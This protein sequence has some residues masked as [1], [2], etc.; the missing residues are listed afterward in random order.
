MQLATKFAPSREACGL[1]SQAGFG[2]AELW[3]DEA[4]LG[5]WREVVDVVS[6]FPLDY[7]LH[8]PNRKLADPLAVSGAVELYRALGCRAMIIH[9]PQ[10]DRYGDALLRREPGLRVAVENHDLS[11]AAFDDWAR[12]SPGLTLDVEHLWLYTLADA[13]LDVLLDV[14]RRFLERHVAKLRHVHLPGYVPGWATHRPMYCSREMVYGLFSLLDEFGFQGQVVS[15]VNS[16]Y[17]TLNELRMDV[18]LH[19]AWAARYRRTSA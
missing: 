2:H 1:A 6:R 8:F 13:P 19:E 10:F 9:Q 14:V 4:T 5:A 15:E 11:P 12:N 16:E 17:Q 3:T 7:A 18:L